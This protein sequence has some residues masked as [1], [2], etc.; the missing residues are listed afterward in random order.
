[1]GF[2]GIRIAGHS[3]TDFK[4]KKA[5]KNQKKYIDD[6]R[7]MMD[8]KIESR[9]RSKK[10]Y[11]DNTFKRIIAFSFCFVI[12][13]IIYAFVYKMGVVVY[14]TSYD[15]YKMSKELRRVEDL[16]AA[17]MLYKSALLYYNSDHLDHAQYEISL[18]LKIT[19]HDPKAIHLMKDILEGQCSTKNTFCKEAQMYKDYIK[20]TNSS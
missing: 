13:C 11:Y 1:M 20:L 15:Q 3:G 10:S 12:L 6:T 18:V 16:N 2:G 14:N 9:D 8:A 5:F 17:D 4:H 7:P 19:P